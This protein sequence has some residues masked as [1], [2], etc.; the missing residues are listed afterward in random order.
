MENS[1]DPDT[2]SHSIAPIVRE[3]PGPSEK[4]VEEEVKCWR[5]YFDMCAERPNVDTQKAY[6]KRSQECQNPFTASGEPIGSH[7]HYGWRQLSGMCAG[8]IAN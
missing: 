7:E 5:R 1:T 6:V 8:E 3:T 4:Q 2:D